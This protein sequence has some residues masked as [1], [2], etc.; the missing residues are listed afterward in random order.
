MTNQ[1]T[2]KQITDFIREIYKTPEDRIPLHAPVFNGNEKKYLLECIDTT[3]VS[4][5]GKFVTLF[6]DKMAEYTGSRFAVAIDNGTDALHITL[7]LAGVE[8]DDEVITQPLTFIATVNAIAYTGAHPVFIDIDNDTLGLSPGKLREFLSANAEVRDGKCFNKTTNRHIIACVPVHVFGHPAKIDEIKLI[9]DEYNIKLIEDAAESLGSKYKGQHT[10][11]FGD[12]GILS[13]NGNKTITT[14][15]GG[16][17]ITNNERLAKE[18]KH[19][20]TQAKVTHE[21]EYIHDK[22]GYNYRMPNINA[23]LGV[24][25]MENLDEFIENKRELAQ[26]YKTF[27]DNCELEFFTEPEDAYSNYWLNAVILKNREA[28]DSFLEYS[29]QHGVMTR[30]AW[31]LMNQLDMYKNCQCGN[32]ENAE[33]LAN[34]LVNIPSSVRS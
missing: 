26:A 30:P 23:A 5:V 8:R 24:A 17:I 4:Y 25:Q 12:M 18:A 13:F 21:W 20:T 7:K 28:R 1:S 33:W 27:F 22:V 3:F 16:M 14:G 6:E 31:R 29:N 32:I 10:G 19:I 9:C 34:R 11:T 15:G 2:Y